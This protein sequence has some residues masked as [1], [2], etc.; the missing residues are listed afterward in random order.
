[1]STGLGVA[2]KLANGAIEGRY[3]RDMNGEAMA[4]N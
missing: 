3:I 2:R 1:M 4:L